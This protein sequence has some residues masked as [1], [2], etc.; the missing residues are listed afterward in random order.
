MS[1]IPSQTFNKFVLFV[2]KYWWQWLDLLTLIMLFREFWY[3]L[4][5]VCNSYFLFSSF[6]LQYFRY[7]L[8]LLS[9]DVN[10]P[11][12]IHGFSFSLRSF[13]DIFFSGACLSMI[14]LMV[15]KKVS[16]DLSTSSL[17]TSRT[18]SQ[19]VFRKLFSNLFS[20]MYW[21]SWWYTSVFVMFFYY[22]NFS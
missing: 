12:V 20:L 16:D 6:A 18:S 9:I 11:L 3:C 8:F 4:K 13:K 21:K 10:I 15:L 22:L 2:V 14:E 19:L 7:V 1:L 5:R 17:C